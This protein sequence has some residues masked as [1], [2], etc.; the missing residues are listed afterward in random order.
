MT[1][2]SMSARNLAKEK[3]CCNM[4]YSH[5]LGFRGEAYLQNLM[6]IGSLLGTVTI[7]LLSS[8]FSPLPSLL[9]LPSSLLSSLSSLLSSLFYRLSSLLSS[10]KS[11]SNNSSAFRD[12]DPPPSGFPNMKALFSGSHA[13]HQ[14]PF[15]AAT[16][17]NIF[18]ASII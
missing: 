9:S 2:G 4:S 14:S 16:W 15:L 13:K 18:H 17:G 3:K 12:Q 6:D 7:R 1:T 11:K 8:L 5:Y 10:G